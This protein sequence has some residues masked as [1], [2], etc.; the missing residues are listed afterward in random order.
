[1]HADEFVLTHKTVFSVPYMQDFVS[2][3]PSE[4]RQRSPKAVCKVLST[5]GDDRECFYCHESGHLIAKCPILE[6]KNQARLVKN[7]KSP[8]GVGFNSAMSTAVLSS[9]SS[10]N[11]CDKADSSFNPFIS[12]GFVSVTGEE[13]DWVPITIL[14]DTGHIVHLFCRPF[15]HLV[16]KLRAIRTI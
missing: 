3:S 7:S 4:R 15:Y 10:Q 16:R 9:S 2:L 5:K 11:E 12:Q 8:T 1:M 14:R 6:R 13:K